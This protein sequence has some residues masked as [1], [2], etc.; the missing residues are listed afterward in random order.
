MTTLTYPHTLVAGTPENVNDLNDNLNAVTTWAAGN[1]DATNLAATAKPATVLGAYRTVHE[2]AF[3]INAG[4][5]AA[6]Y[7]ATV[8]GTATFIATPTNIAF[9]VCPITLAD[10]AVSGLTT[11]FR[12]QASTIVNTIAPAVTFTYALAPITSNA[13]AAG[14]TSIASVGASLGSVALAS[15]GA[16]SRTISAGSDFTISSNEVYVL[17]VTLSGTTAATSD[18]HAL[19]RLQVHHI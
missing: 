3:S 2:S 16:S 14:T 12:V 18:V 17:I 7:V 4:S 15:P 5:T 9:S 1:I 19:L 13:G 10:Y 8:Q 11:Q 6:T